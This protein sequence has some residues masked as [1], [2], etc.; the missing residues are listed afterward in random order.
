MA[1]LTTRAERQAYRDEQV[2]K[3]LN[4][5]VKVPKPPEIIEEP[6]FPVYVATEPKA[7]RPKRRRAKAKPVDEETKNVI[8]EAKS[9]IDED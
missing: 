2:H 4:K 8:D 9:L 6:E 3:L 5:R 7:K 1:E